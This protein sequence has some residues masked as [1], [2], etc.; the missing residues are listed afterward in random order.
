MPRSV[1]QAR[2]LGSSSGT[3]TTS[4]AMNASRCNRNQGGGNALSGLMPSVGMGQFNLTYGLGRAYGSLKDRRKVFCFN[5]LGWTGTR[6]S[7]MRAPSGGVKKPCQGSK[8]K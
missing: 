4:S 5:Q 1:S 3:R 8:N 6:F 7:Q 2:A